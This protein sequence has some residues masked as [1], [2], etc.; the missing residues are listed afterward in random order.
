MPQRRRRRARVAARRPLPVTYGI[1]QQFTDWW[2]ER[3]KPF[4]LT[5]FHAPRPKKRSPGRPRH[6]V[7]GEQLVVWRQELSK[8]I[9]QLGGGLRSFSRVLK[10]VR[11]ISIDPGTIKKLLAE[12]RNKE[13]ADI[14]ARKYPGRFL[15]R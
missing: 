4:R 9:E 13:L 12:A 3:G 7:T 1:A 2:L 8:Q 10:E 15:P 5:S 6:K 14:S 11:E